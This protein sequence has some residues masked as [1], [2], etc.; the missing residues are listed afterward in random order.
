MRKVVTCIVLGLIASVL[1]A[2]DANLTLYTIVNEIPGSLR[3]S[4]DAALTPQTWDHYITSVRFG[5]Q[6]GVDPEGPL[7]AI[8]NLYVN[9]LTNTNHIDEPIVS[10]QAYHMEH[11]DP[12]ITDYIQYTVTPDG[13]S[14]ILSSASPESTFFTSWS[15]WLPGRRVLSKKFSLA[16]VDSG[17]DS[18]R[19]ATS[20]LYAGT[21]RFSITVQ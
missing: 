16:L 2:S 15:E 12:E 6:E 9:F 19:N 17:E 14:P 20:G 4:K 18:I 1:V 10:I 13:G 5:Q 8:D 21:I 7:P 11:I 3:I